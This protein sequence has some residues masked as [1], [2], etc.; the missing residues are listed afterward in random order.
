MDE[1]TVPSLLNPK[2]INFS[3]VGD[4]FDV[5]LDNLFFLVEAEVNR[6]PNERLIPKIR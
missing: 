1:R 4:L 2:S 5:F 6:R 3:S